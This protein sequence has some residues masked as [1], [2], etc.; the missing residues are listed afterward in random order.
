MQWYIGGL[1]L[2]KHVLK[3]KPQTQIQ[4]KIPITGHTHLDQKT[5][6]KI[7]C[8]SANITHTEE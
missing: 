3:K 1:V 2:V 8:S 5:L 6:T 7:Y 4:S